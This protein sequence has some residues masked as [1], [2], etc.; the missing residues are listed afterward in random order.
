[1]PLLEHTKIDRQRRW[2][3]ESRRK[4]QIVSAADYWN[5]CYRSKIS[6]LCKQIKYT[7]FAVIVEIEAKTVVRNTCISSLRLLAPVSLNLID[8]KHRICR[9]SKMHRGTQIPTA[10]CFFINL[11]HC[12]KTSVRGL[13]K[14]VF[15]IWEFTMA[16]KDV[17]GVVDASDISSGTCEDKG[18]TISNRS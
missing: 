16:A 18:M 12:V 10:S 7:E 4:L 6:C 17:G 1:M 13:F 2:Y 8:S 9:G 14:H 3:L 11:K 15:S 5:H